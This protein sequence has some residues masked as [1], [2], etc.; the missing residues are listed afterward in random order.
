MADQELT[1]AAWLRVLNELEL[2]LDTASRVAT[3]D[4]TA[5]STG[6][7]HPAPAS[8][9]QPPAGI[10]PIPAHLEERARDLL[11][12]QKKLVRELDAAR[13]LAGQHLAALRIV[14]PARE[15]DRS[16]YLDVTG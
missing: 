11:T 4:A 14:P 5:E 1:T 7:D 8:V 10:G 13:R 9:W 15:A 6:A 3:A 12:C 2:S 16:V